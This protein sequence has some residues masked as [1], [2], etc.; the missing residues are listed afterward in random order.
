MN[1]TDTRRKILDAVDAN[2]DAQ[3]AAT[4]DLVRFRVGKDALGPCPPLLRLGG[5]LRFA[6][7]M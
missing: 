5:T 7:P 1:A 6:Y 3:L 2:F 4:K